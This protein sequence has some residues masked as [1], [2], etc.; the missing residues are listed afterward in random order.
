M[1]CEGHST[2]IANLKGTAE[3]ELN[4]IVTNKKNADEASAVIIVAKATTEADSKLIAAAR[5][6]IESA[7]AELL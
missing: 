1:A 4:S 5:K 2:A 6:E 7:A 3:A